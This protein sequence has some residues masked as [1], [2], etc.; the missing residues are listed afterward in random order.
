M[1]SV[2]QVLKTLGFGLGFDDVFADWVVANRVNDPNLADGQYGYT[3]I[4]PASFETDAE[5]RASD[6]PTDKRTDVKQYGTDYVMLRGKG[7]YQIDFAGAT[8]V[9]LAPITAHSGKYLWWGGRMDNSDTMLTR[10][11]DLTKLS[12]ATLTFWTWYDIEK[13]YDYAYVQVSTDGKHWQTLPGQTTTNT[14]PTGANYGNGYTATSDDWIQEKIDLTSYA[15]QKV[16]VRFEYLTDAGVTHAGM[17]LD[18]IEIPE[19][20]YRYDA[21]S[22]D[23]GWAA[24]G[25][26]R[27]ANVTPQRWLLQLVTQKSGK[28]TIERLPLNP[29][30]SG[31]WVVSLNS[32]DKAYLIVSGL[33]RV[34]TEPAE[35]WYSITAQD[36]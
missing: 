19:L 18:D 14:D 6:L 25:F 20:G 34:T 35:Y 2:N 12:K 16:Q 28:T 3:R 24:Q 1:T 36:Q 27:N 9:G 8:L 31:R 22:G 21:E 11:F 15:G 32:G 23:E 30:N 10:E 13:D 29:D 4:V 17:F 5:Y 7:N 33:T 26:M